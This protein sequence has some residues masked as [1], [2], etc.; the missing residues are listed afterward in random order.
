MVQAVNRGSPIAKARDRH[1]TVNVRFVVDEVALGQEF[2]RVIR[3]L[4]S[5]PLHQNSTLFIY[6]LLLPE[7]QT[8]EA[9]GTFKNGSALDR[10]VFYLF[11]KS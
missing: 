3:F 11:F 10:K 2:L 4:P 7:G 9:W 8:G 1:W 6:K 5:I